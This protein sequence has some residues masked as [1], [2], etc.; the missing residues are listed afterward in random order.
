MKRTNQLLAPA[1]PLSPTW[2]QYDES[3]L[4]ASSKASPR[5]GEKQTISGETTFSSGNSSE[6]GLVSVI[7]N[8]EADDRQGQWPGS[9]P[10]PTKG[11]VPIIWREGI[12][13]HWQYQCS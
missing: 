11:D 3:C 7:R 8:A 5:H 13:R 12:V 9:S 2:T 1:S 10:S 6:L 4:A